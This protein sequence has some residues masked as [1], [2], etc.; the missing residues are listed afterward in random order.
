MLNT[1]LQY[2]FFFFKPQTVKCEVNNCCSFKKNIAEHKWFTC[3]PPMLCTP[4]LLIKISL[5]I[6]IG[7][8]RLNGHFLQLKNKSNGNHK[9]DT[10]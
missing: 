5:L 6:L 10:V 9:Q 4:T 2:M 1:V 7:H 3:M 8:T